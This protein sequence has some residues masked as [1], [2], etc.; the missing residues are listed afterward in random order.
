MSLTIYLRSLGP[1][2]SMNSKWR[3]MLK[4]EVTCLVINSL[5]T[6]GVRFKRLTH[7]PPHTHTYTHTHVNLNDIS[8]FTENQPSGSLDFPQA[9]ISTRTSIRSLTTAH[10]IV[11]LWWLL[12]SPIFNVVAKSSIN[13]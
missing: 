13:N 8:W 10:L 2:T 9:C 1:W 12:Y 3:P 7:D 4:R 6:Y 11:I 5:C